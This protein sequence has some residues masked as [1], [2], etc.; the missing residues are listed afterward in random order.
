MAGN[1]KTRI[2][3]NTQTPELNEDI[4]AS[5]QPAVRRSASDSV[6]YEE[7]ATLSDTARVASLEQRIRQLPEIRQTRVLA[8]SRAIRQGQYR[9]H[10]DQIA[11]AMLSEMMSSGRRRSAKSTAEFTSLEH[12]KDSIPEQQ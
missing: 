8:L 3:L 7:K 12:A 11:N 5:R 4:S 2:A 1:Q 6:S 10:S 9:V